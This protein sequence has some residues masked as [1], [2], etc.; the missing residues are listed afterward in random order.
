MVYACT[1][2]CV[3]VLHNYQQYR[4]Q[5]VLIFFICNERALKDFRFKLMKCF[6]YSMVLCWTSSTKFL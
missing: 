4:I 5:S 6:K 3:E 1:H 2:R